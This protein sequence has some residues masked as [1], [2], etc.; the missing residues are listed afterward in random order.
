MMRRP[1]RSLTTLKEPISL[2]RSASVREAVN[3]MTEGRVGCVLI[4]EAG[5]LAG[6]FTERDVLCKVVTGNLDVDRTTLE[7]VMT[8]NPECLTL[9]DRI[10]YA[11]NKMSVGGFRHIPLVDEHGRPAGVVAM[12][13]IVDYIVDLFPGEILNLPPEP[14]LSVTRSREGA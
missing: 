7:A 13:N 1:I 2:P 4:E 14:G 10:A 8:P 9:D 5:Q 12:R 11:L 3:K 6:V